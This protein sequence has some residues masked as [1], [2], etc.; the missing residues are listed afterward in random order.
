M[1]V[2]YQ[3]AKNASVSFAHALWGYGSHQKYQR[4]LSFTSP[5]DLADYF[6][7]KGD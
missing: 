1:D 6:F 2:D 5:Q 7:K 4:Y 3:C